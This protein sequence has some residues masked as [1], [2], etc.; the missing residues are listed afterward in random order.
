[1]IHGMTQ[2]WTPSRE[3]SQSLSLMVEVSSDSMT[4]GVICRW[5]DTQSVLLNEFSGYQVSLLIAILSC[6]YVD[7][8]ELLIHYWQDSSSVSCQRMMDGAASPP[9]Y[10]L[11]RISWIHD[12]EDWE[13]IYSR[14]SKILSERRTHALD[15][16]KAR[17]RRQNRIPINRQSK[18]SIG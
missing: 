15:I 10:R 8:I 6:Q 14:L 2:E 12:R 3:R 13:H 4:N 1:M 17:R 16:K 18:G 9:F 5:T 7:G 11:P